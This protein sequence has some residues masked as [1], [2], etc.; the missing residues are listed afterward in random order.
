V[1]SSGHILAARPSSAGG[2]YLAVDLWKYGDRYHKKIH[3]LV[4]EAFVGPRPEGYEAAHLDDNSRNN[5]VSNLAWVTRSENQRMNSRVFM[6]TFAARLT[7][8]D[9]KEIRRLYATG[10]YLQ[11]ELAKMFGVTAPHISRIVTKTRWED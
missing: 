8:T 4:L 7:P 11:R 5:H 9:V 3:L 10:E 2:T 6:N 1:K